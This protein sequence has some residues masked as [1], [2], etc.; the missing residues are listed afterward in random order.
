MRPYVLRGFFDTQLLIAESKIGLPRDYRVFW[1]GHSGSMESKYTTDKKL[2]ADVLEDMREKYAKSLKFLQTES[3]GLSDE[4]KQSLEK[5]LTGTVLQKIFGY[6]KEESEQLMNLSDEELQKELQK[7]LG[8]AM[9]PESVRKKALQDY[10]DISKKKTK[11]VMI[12]IDYVDVYF[13]QGFEFVSAIGQDRA[14][15]RL[16]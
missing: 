9:D 16:P 4:D 8:N 15:M 14:I 11:Q 12:P 13:E 7:K 3:K 2:P 5:V 6:S 10:K 1:M